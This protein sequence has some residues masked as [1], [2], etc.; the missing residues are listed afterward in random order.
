M[1]E[2]ASGVLRRVLWIASSILRGLTILGVAAGVAVGVAGVAWL[3]DTPPSNANEWIARLV[4]LGALL[5]PPAALLLFVAGLRDLRHLPERARA[6]PADAR[7]RALDVR[8]QARRTSQPRGIVGA[9]AALFRLGRLVLGSRE[10]LSPFASVAIVLR[11]AMLIAA[12][13]A[14]LAAV[15]EIPAALVFLLILALT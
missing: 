2:R 9:I 12:V 11:P 8:E 4:I 14:A 5:T 3:A 1:S 13:F 7:T 10:A 6:L 15:L